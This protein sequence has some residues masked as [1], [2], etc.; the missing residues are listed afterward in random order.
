LPPHVP[1]T[2]PARHN[3][4]QGKS[5]AFLEG[6][7]RYRFTPVSADLPNQHDRLLALQIIDVNL[8]RAAE[9]LRV[10]EEYCRFVLA[11]AALTA[12]C[13]SLRD[14]LH[15]AL[16]PISRAER[17]LARDTPNDVGATSGFAEA[18]GRD[19]S[20]FSIEQIAVKNG[21]R[22]KEAL[23]A[24]EEF[25]KTLHPNA[26][27]E[28][29]TLRYEWYTLERDCHLPL[30]RAKALLDA[31]LYVL[32]D[33]GSTESAF[34]LRAK[35]LI[36]AGVHILQLRDKK[37]DDRTL[38]ARARLL[39]RLIDAAAPHPL[40]IVND[41]PDIAAL[42]S[43][44]GVHLGQDELDVRDA[45][46]IIGPD[47]LVGVS[48]HTIEQARQAASD[49]A[50]YIGCGPTF[51]SGT[52]DFDHFPGLDFLRQVAAEIPLPAFAI[53]G[54]TLDNLPQVLVTGFTRVSVSGAITHAGDP[55][56]EAR[57]FLAALARG[58]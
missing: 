28:I 20:I 29:G 58:A 38:L 53:G 13:K 57:N 56:A 5:P 46:R 22:V 43:A 33:G 45:R 21:E 15:A 37:L 3:F 7:I 26:A 6:L 51:P 19:V 40:L 35:A 52:K 17:L 49:R 42:S 18:F 11:D 48:T 55:A 30:D 12:R 36:E 16:D 9:G 54:I 24:I 8:N 23:R 10:V 4:S 14:R 1:F 41:R 25:T 2:Q 32:T 44:D 39:R 47:R 27:A 31:R 34:V 50:D